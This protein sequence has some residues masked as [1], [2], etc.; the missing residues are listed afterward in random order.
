LFS[1]IL[2]RDGSSRFGANNRWGTF[3]AVSGAWLIS[4]ESFFNSTFIDFAKVRASYGISG[5]DQIPNFAYRALLNGEGVYVFNDLLTNGVA[6]GRA[7]NPDLK[8]ETTHQFNI[9]VDLRL[10]QSLDFTINYF[11]KN[12]N[13]LLFQPDV[14]GVLGTYG[15]G[16]FPPFV[17]A[18]DV[19][20][21]G[22]EI[23][24]G[25]GNNPNRNW[26]FYGS[27]NLTTLKNKVVRVP[28]GVD[29]IPGASFGV[30]GNTATRFEA[31]Q[32]IGYFIGFETDGIYQTQQEIDNSPVTQAG[33]QPGD[34]R[35]VDQNG[36][37]VINFNDD[38]DRVKLGSPI[39]DVTIGL[40]LTLRH[41]GFDISA[42]IYA[43]LG[44]EIIRNYER[45]QPYANQLDY[46]IDRWAGPG[47]SNEV[48]RVTTGA[49]RNNV[50]SDYFVENGS[51]MRMRNIQLGYT[52]P[53]RWMENLNV[54]SFRLYVSA[55]N[56][57]TVTQYQGYDPDIGN[58]GG[59]LSAGVDY[60]FYPQARTIMG[61]FNIK[62]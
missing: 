61:G 19:S 14:S 42:N 34:L 52:F 10:W 51:F 24:M 32:P 40:N 22:L 50:F 33:A 9:G 26:V 58:F 54:Q 13:D 5:N 56:M 17:N 27:L 59:P 1:V 36:D 11:V 31:G 55:N 28:D 29:F 4:E 48:P 38:S 39:P 62:F 16:G 23:E 8:W 21:K 12:T 6:I 7:S 57:F 15:A 25:Y 45:Q 46:V 47:T 49:T 20:N 41:K 37:G 53:K 35:F 2:R 3:P 44:Q 43:A 60:G 18:G 30:G